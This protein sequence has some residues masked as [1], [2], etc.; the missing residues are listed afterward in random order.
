MS[1]KTKTTQNTLQVVLLV[2]NLDVLGFTLI[3]PKVHEHSFCTL[4]TEEK[5]AARKQNA[6]N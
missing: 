5:P 6:G 1:Q 4:L 3:A 2:G